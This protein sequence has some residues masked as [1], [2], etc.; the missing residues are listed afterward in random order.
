MSSHPRHLDL[1]FFILIRMTQIDDPA[2]AAMSHVFIRP[3]TRAGHIV[4]NRVMC[5]IQDIGYPCLAGI[6]FDFVNR[7]HVN[8]QAIHHCTLSGGRA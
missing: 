5:D 6:F 7:L 1:H 3:T 8:R 2:Q 4:T